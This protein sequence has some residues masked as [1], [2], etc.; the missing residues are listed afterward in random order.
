MQIT[1]PVND[2]SDVVREE[3][4]PGV[5]LEWAT[6]P[7]HQARFAAALE[8]AMLDAPA[9]RNGRRQRYSGAPTARAS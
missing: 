3:L 1:T 5:L 6:E 2:S 9:R 7:A 4:V 8:A